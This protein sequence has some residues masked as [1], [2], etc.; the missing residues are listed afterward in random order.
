MANSPNTAVTLAAA[1]KDQH[2]EIVRA[3]P[4]TSALQREYPID[5]KRMNG[6]KVLMPIKLTRS[7]GTTRSKPNNGAFT[8][9]D[10]VP[11]VWEEAQIEPYQF[12]HTETTDYESLFRMENGEPKAYV[13]AIK[14]LMTG[15]VQDLS[16]EIEMD[17]LY[18]Q[19]PTGFGQVEASSAS[20]SVVF[21]PGQWAPGYWHGKKGAFIQ[22]ADAAWAGDED[23]SEAIAS[24]DLDNRTIVVGNA[25]TLDAGDLVAPAGSVTTNA[26]PASVVYQQMIGLDRMI[27][28]T[29]GTFFNINVATYPDSWKGRTVT[30]TGDPTM[31]KILKGVSAVAITGCNVGLIAWVPTRAFERMNSD[32][33]GLRRLDGSYR[34]SK[35][36]S[37]AEK[38]VFYSQ[39][40]KLEVRPHSYIKE[41]EC[42]ILPDGAS[43]LVKRY[44]S[45]DITFKRPGGSGD[46]DMAIDTAGAAGFEFRAYSGQQIFCKK[47]AWMCKVSG[48]TYS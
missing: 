42:F 16:G 27:S 25:Q 10:S 36:E 46:D 24:V 5:T 22:I 29:S 39:T 40:G 35:V 18:G 8:L 30:V 3:I 13:D 28:A 31:A 33:A 34:H 6:R 2:D 1:I 43:G 37:G 20:T 7:H 26:T 12:V 19:S 32:I 14:E 45:T 23:T 4:E 15:M 11:A 17:L 38:L 44:A 41:G 47:P 48:F 9:R 21:Q